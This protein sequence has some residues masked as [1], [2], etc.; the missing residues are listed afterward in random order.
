MK[1]LLLLAL[2]CLSLQISHAQNNDPWSAYMTPSAVHAWLA[3]YIGDFNME[4]NMFAA[5]GQVGPS[6]SVESTHSL[7]LGG[8]FLELRQSGSMMG[9]PYQGIT[10][11]GFN[12]VD[13]KLTLTTITNM[14][15]GTLTVTGD[16]DEESKSAELFG[17]LANPVTQATVQ[18]RQFITFVDE[19]TILIESFDTMGDQPEVKTLSYRF[20]RITAKP[21]KP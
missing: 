1:K 9:M 19:N 5:D 2:S 4:I 12:N 17:T 16:W 10:T 8:R 6:M 7:L 3:Q 18:L 11:I 13:R 14:G 21:S 20:T 15:T